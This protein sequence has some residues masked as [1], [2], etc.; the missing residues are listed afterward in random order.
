VPTP[1]TDADHQTPEHAPASGSCPPPRPPSCT[2]AGTTVLDIRTPPEVAQARIPGAVAIDLFAP[3][4]SQ[5]LDDLDRDG[6]YLLYCRSGNRT[7]SA[8]SLMAQ[9]GFR[10]VAD[11]DG[12][13]IA[14]ANAGLPLEQ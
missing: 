11:I 1:S 5:R 9:L 7:S 10:D 12:G 14:W 13:I 8:R 3:D 6:H 2:S 4:F